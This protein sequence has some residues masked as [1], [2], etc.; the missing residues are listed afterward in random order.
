M[1]RPFVRAFP[2][3]L[4]L[5]LGV[6]VW[7]D[8]SRSL[9]PMLLAVALAFVCGWLARGP[10]RRSTRPSQRQPR[11]LQA[12]PVVIRAEP[13]IQVVPYRV[14]VP[15]PVVTYLEPAPA[16]RARRSESEESARQAVMESLDRPAYEPFAKAASSAQ[17]DLSSALVNLGFKKG[18][19]GRAADAAIA[20]L[21]T[22]DLGTLLREALK[23]ARGTSES[24]I[25]RHEIA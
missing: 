3:A 2:W 21:G 10:R 12:R 8:H 7:R 23:V 20:K 16:P 13:Q 22:V 9:V 25:A 6:A 1:R 18:Q 14:Q 15:Q 17:A 4:S 24:L 5:L 11:V 19:A